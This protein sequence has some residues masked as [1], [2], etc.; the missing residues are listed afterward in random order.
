MLGTSP[1]FDLEGADQYFFPGL[2]DVF[3]KLVKEVFS[4]CNHLIFFLSDKARSAI[5][6]VESLKRTTYNN[7]L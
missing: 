7:L 2:F 3:V 1:Y 6:V 5:V 4:G